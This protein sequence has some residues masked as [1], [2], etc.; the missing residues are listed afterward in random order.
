MRVPAR[1]LL[2][3][4][5]KVVQSSVQALNDWPRL[6]AWRVIDEYIDDRGGPAAL[7]APFE[8]IQLTPLQ[9]PTGCFSLPSR[10]GRGGVRGADTKCGGA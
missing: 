8:K 9:L 4:C 5:N 3:L 1:L 10:E 6:T 7:F 2:T